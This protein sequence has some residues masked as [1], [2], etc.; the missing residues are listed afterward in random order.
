MKKNNNDAEQV[1]DYTYNP[2]NFVMVNIPDSVIKVDLA[3][4]KLIVS[5]KNA[6]NTYLNSENPSKVVINTYRGSGQ[7]CVI[8]EGSE[9]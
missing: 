1:I 8:Y 6:I 2:G 3:N 9:E 5:D 4:K 7:Y